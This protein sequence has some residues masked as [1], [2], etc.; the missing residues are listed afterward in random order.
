M[1]AN[2]PDAIYQR[3]FSD[4]DELGK[5]A[6]WLEVA[7]YLQRFIA[8]DS[9]VLD[10]ACDRGHFIG[11]I[12]ARERWAT[13]ARDVQAYLG[14]GVQFVQSDGLAL[15][16]RLPAEYFDVVFMSNYLEHL[17]TSEAVVDQLA[18]VRELLHPGGRAIVLQPNIRLI[19]NRYWDFIDHHVALTDRSLIEAVELAGLAVEHKVT[20][21]L[22]YTTKSRLPQ[23]RRFVRAYLALRPAWLLFGKQ[24]LVVARRL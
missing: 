19:G 12:V 18:V 1:H 2:P 15:A 23:G 7:R 14:S 24:T 21:F 13:D 17:P 22:P 20:R 3:R 9:A 8:P 11:S 4:S 16:T 5:R 10:I 6:V